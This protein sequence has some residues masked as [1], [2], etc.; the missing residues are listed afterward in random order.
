M[1]L[2]LRAGCCALIFGLVSLHSVGCRAGAGTRSWPNHAQSTNSRTAQPSLSTAAD[3]GPVGRDP[4]RT[5]TRLPLASTNDVKPLVA[6]V[7][8][9]PTPQV[10]TSNEPSSSSDDLFAGQFEL[11]LQ[12]LSDIVL[13]RN[14]SLQAMTFAWRSATQRYPQ[15][16]A[17]DDPVFMGMIAPASV[18]SSLVETAYQVGASQK[19]P[20]FG[21]RPAR[22]AIAQADAKAMFHDV[23]DARLQLVQTTRAAFFEYFLV[24]RMLEI[25]RANLTLTGEF[26]ET[27]QSKYENNQ[28]TEQDVFQ[29]DVE[30]A[31]TQR[32]L[33]ELERMMRVATA[34]LNTLLRRDPNE[35]LPPAPNSLSDSANLPPAEYLRQLAISQRPDLAA[36]RARVQSERGAVVLAEKQFYPDT[37]VYGRYDTFWQPASTQGPLRG[38]VGIN[39]NMP[40]YRQKLRAAVNEAQFRLSQRQAEYNQKMVDVQFEV[41]AASAQIQETTKAIDLYRDK[42]IPAAER[43]VATTRANYNVGTT[44]FLNL[45]TAQQQL[46]MQREQQQQVIAAYH[47]RLADLERTIGGPVPEVAK[48]EEI[49]VPDLR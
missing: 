9:Q 36:L 12:Q 8:Y 11:S 5:V 4:C 34:R 2:S 46:L 40:I 48:P 21:K 23:R 1:T 27:A 32:R 13:A 29:A 16:I 49:P 24:E 10:A 20:W 45:L 37:E 39:M 44:T 28:V 7:A 15:V 38:Q 25:N 47:S 14:A 17:L 43:T 22:G 42:L 30:Y 6:Q 3:A 35:L 18:D 19:L 33:L 41:E 31:T 26:R